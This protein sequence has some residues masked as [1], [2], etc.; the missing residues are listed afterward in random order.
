MQFKN[1]V[2]T[3]CSVLLIF[4]L[5]SCG[6]GTQGTGGVTVE[7]RIIDTANNPLSAITITSIESGNSTTSDS[8]G[9]FLLDTEDKDVIELE[10]RGNNLVASTAI[11]NVSSN[12]RKLSATFRVDKT[13][14]KVTPENIREREDDND[15]NGGDDDG[16]DDSDS[17]DDDDNSGS[18]S[19]SGGSNSGSGNGGGDDDGDDDSDSNDDNDDNDDNSGSHGGGSG[20]N[21]G[22]DDDSSNDDHGDNSGHDDE[23]NHSNDD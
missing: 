19:N 1:K 6:G 20:S 5:T 13:K 12:T 23:S 14:N 15:D 4:L 11:S 2:F 10:F 22:S 9:A 3:C 16:D 21:G 8:N 7:G 17:N 18:G